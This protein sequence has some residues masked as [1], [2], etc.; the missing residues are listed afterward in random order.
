MVNLTMLGTGGN[1]PSPNRFC[2]SAF[3]NYNGKKMLIDCGEGAQISMKS[4]GCG[5]KGID[6]IMITHLHGD[7]INGLIGLLATLGN[8]EKRTPLTIIGPKGI[9]RAISAMMILIEGL[10]YKLNIVE[11]PIGSFCIN[12]DNLKDIEIS[13]HTLDH[14]I[15]CIGYS[16][17]FKRNRKFCSKNAIKNNIPKNL[18]SHLQKGNSY[19]LDDHVYTPDMVLGN[20]RKGIKISYITDTRPI[21]SIVDFVRDSDLFVCEGMYG[22]DM[23]ISKAVKNKHMTFREAATLAK[24]ANVKKL[25][26]THFSPSVDKA[27]YFIENATS[28]F[29][30]TLIGYD[31]ISVEVSY[32]SK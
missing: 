28:V 25:L 2:S 31:G 1:V 10:P 22:D 27:D 7:H 29:K 12:D 20:E 13:T 6:L 11:N 5:F 17:Y 15:E 3:I 16:L 9:K 4:I 26:L 19:F 24:N 32:P 23:D 14:S 8:A 18:W 21:E 30:N